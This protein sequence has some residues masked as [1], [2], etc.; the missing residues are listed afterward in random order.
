MVFEEKVN[1]IRYYKEWYNS[2]ISKC[3]IDANLREV[4]GD[5]ESQVE[6]LSE[7]LVGDLNN[8]LKTSQ[9]DAQ[10]REF[11]RKLGF[12]LGGGW[13]AFN[14]DL[15]GNTLQ[16]GCF[17]PNN[18]RQS[19]G[20]YI[21]YE[22]PRGKPAQPF[23]PFVPVEAWKVVC[24]RYSVPYPDFQSISF[25]RWVYK[26]NLPIHITEGLKK[27]LSLIS[28]GFIA[29]GL[30]GI[31]GGHRAIKEIPGDKTSKTTGH[32]LVPELKQFTE[33]ARKWF[34]VFDSDERKNVLKDIQQAA[35]SLAL[36]L[37]KNKQEEIRIIELPVTYKGVDDYLVGKGVESFE[38]L[39]EEAKLLKDY[40]FKY[41]NKLSGISKTINQRFLGTIEA[42]EHMKLICIRSAKGSGKSTS[43]A[44][45]VKNH[46]RKGLPVLLISHRIQLAKVLSQKIG[47][48]YI[49]DYLSKGSE[50]YFV[51][52]FGICADSLHPY[53]S[54]AFNVTDWLN[55]D[56]L[57]ILDEVEQLTDHILFS[58]TDIKE[59]RVEVFENKSAILESIADPFSKGKVLIADADL[60]NVSKDF[61]KNL[62]GFTNE[63]TFVLDNTYKVA[64]D[65]KLYCYEKPEYLLSQ[66]IS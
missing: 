63:Q 50:G 59:N 29:I 44:E 11:Q 64:K 57:L 41:E 55:G 22:I 52:G 15:D 56:V 62:G 31:Y 3:L 42:P 36:Q 40:F 24:N 33:Q 23:L 1:I 13:F 53:S 26:N 39:Q 16:W 45:L 61:I 10:H 9:K 25:W 20:R 47:I 65:R 43:I 54:A 30:N 19:K 4:D 28:Q 58:Q 18:P 2:G 8:F 66:I 21:K 27:A 46:A 37:K 51:S 48:P 32:Y 7:I 60:S 6:H 49:T 34:I 35:T 17:K 5:D 38:C 12:I 14:S